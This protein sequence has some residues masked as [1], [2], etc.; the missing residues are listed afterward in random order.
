MHVK[1]SVSPIANARTVRIAPGQRL[2]VNLVSAT[3]G[4]TEASIDIESDLPVV[5]GQWLTTSN[6]FEI[7]TVSDYPVLGTVSLPT[8]LFTPDQAVAATGAVPSDDTVPE[9]T[10]TSTTATTT[11]T[12]AVAGATTTTL[13]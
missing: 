3:T 4:R 1:G 13:R 11:T 8:D 2:V 12:T 5:A 7:M 6:P 9:S 10:T